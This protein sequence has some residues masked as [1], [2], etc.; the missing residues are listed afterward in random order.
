MSA[1]TDVFTSI[2]NAIRAKAGVQTTYKP[3]EMATAIANL[4]SVVTKEVVCLSVNKQTH[5]SCLFMFEE[6]LVR[7]TS[8]TEG[9]NIQV[10][11][12]ETIQDFVYAL[13]YNI[14]R[15]IYKVVE[16]YSLYYFVDSIDTTNLNN[17]IDGTEVVNQPASD[18]RFFVIYSDASQSV[19]FTFTVKTYRSGTS[20][21]WWVSSAT[22]SKTLLHSH[23]F[24][25]KTSTTGYG[26]LTI[27]AGNTT[28]TRNRPTT[29]Q[30]S[31][32]SPTSMK[33]YLDGNQITTLTV[34]YTSGR[35]NTYPNNSYTTTD[36][37]V[38]FKS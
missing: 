28:A 18:R 26:G 5:S 29:T 13:N 10:I 3:S 34:Q 6:D 20:Y 25:L 31:S 4:P 35:E 24:T 36:R 38:K 22:A 7:V 12:S 19:V 30:T 2:A 32:A 33:V 14:T 17:K 1:L 21:Y 11:C 37:D 27:D 15:T 8:M 9:S 16:G 23:G